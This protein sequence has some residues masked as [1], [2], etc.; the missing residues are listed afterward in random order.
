MIVNR[1]LALILVLVMLLFL[2]ACESSNDLSTEMPPAESTSSGT[3]TLEI[4]PPAN[5][6][7]EGEPMTPDEI[8]YYLAT[9]EAN[10]TE[11]RTGKALEPSSLA[12]FRRFAE[13]DDGQPFY[14]INLIKEN[15]EPQY[16][17]NWQGERA[18]TVLEA[19]KLYSQACYPIMGKTGTYSI[20]GVTFA[21]P[22][23]VNTGIDVEDWDQFYLIA[24]P[25]RKAFMELLASDAYADAIVHKNAGDKDTLLIPVTGGTLTVR[26]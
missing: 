23:V 5:I 4:V 15:E 18:G 14:M 6:S 25:N 2:V 20:T 21:S 11:E 24:Y 19:K 8:E 1:R 17:D 22:A 13:E 12:N 9:I 10:L 16:P 3:D 26:D 7:K